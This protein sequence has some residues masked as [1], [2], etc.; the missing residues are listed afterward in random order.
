MLTTNKN[1]ATLEVEVRCKKCNTLLLKFM[2][3]GTI[4][5]KCRKCKCI[6]EFHFQ[7]RAK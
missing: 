2:G 3:T 6:Q 7:E 4:E 5:I 1:N